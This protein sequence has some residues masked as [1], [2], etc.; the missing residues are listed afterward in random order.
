[1]RAWIHDPVHTLVIGVEAA[2]VGVQIAIVHFLPGAEAARD[3]EG[4]Q[5]RTIGKGVVGYHGDAGLGLDRTAALGHQKHIDFG[6]EAA[7]DRQ[8]AAGCGIVDDFRVLEHI[9]A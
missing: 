5:R 1:M 7:G 8:H 2:D 6:V 3:Q 4:I 9:H